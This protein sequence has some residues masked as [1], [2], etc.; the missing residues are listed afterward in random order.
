[1]RTTMLIACFTAMPLAAQDLA[2]RYEQVGT[3]TGALNGEPVTLV[4]TLDLEGERSSITVSKRSSFAVVTAEAKSVASDGTLTTPDI[5]FLIGPLITGLSHNTDIL[6]NSEGGF[7]VADVD[8]GGRVPVSNFEL[9][10]TSLSY[11][12]EATVS[13][14]IRENGVFKLDP[15]RQP[16][17]LTGKFEG[18]PT[19][20][21]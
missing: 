8:I 9:T 17:E 15:E 3:F 4:A 5:G 19:W 1:M 11:S 13:P 16:A 12:I 10:E 6:I 2:A 21:K 14:V 20:K 7:Y 18:T